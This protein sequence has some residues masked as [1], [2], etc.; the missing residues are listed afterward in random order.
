MRRQA[1]PDADKVRAALVLACHRM[2]HKT[3]KLGSQRTTTVSFAGPV[4][5][6]CLLDQLERILQTC[7]I[8]MTW[9]ACCCP[10]LHSCLHL[11]CM[12]VIH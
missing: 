12:W 7:L 8:R 3:D 2:P 10:H 4:G 1:M 11:S 6:S 5:W 9:Q